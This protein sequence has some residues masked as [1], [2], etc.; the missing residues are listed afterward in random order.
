MSDIKRAFVTTPSFDLSW[1]RMG[2]NDDDLE[3]LQNLLLQDPASGDVIPELGGA[4]KVRIPLR[5]T[6]KRGGG[7]VIYVDVVVKEKIYLLLAYPKNVQTDLTSEQ[8]KVL[9]K[10]IKAIKEE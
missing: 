9:R 4:R 7:R 3:E 10:L 6:G 5:N 2:L 1:D 8:K